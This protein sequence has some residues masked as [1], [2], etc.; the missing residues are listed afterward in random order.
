[1]HTPNRVG[2][3]RYLT[4]SLARDDVTKASP[5]EGSFSDPAPYIPTA[6]QSGLETQNIGALMTLSSMTL[7]QWQN[8]TAAAKMEDIRV[9]IGTQPIGVEINGFAVTDE[10]KLCICPFVM[11]ADGPTITSEWVVANGYQAWY[12]NTDTE[13]TAD[14]HKKFSFDTKFVLD[15]PSGGELFV[16]I[17][18]INASTTQVTAA[19]I[20]FELS[21]R[22]DF[23]AVNSFQRGR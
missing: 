18:A 1:M 19:D 7:D 4:S 21:A 23:Y 6:W 14:G 20:Y 15:N 3:C 10:D 9:E 17:A 8:I 5:T 13:D 22:Y 16:G 2:N 12:L 11:I